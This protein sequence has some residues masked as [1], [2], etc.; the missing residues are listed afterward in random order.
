M[1]TATDE[2]TEPCFWTTEY[3]LRHCR[4]YRVFSGDEPIGFVEEIL[5]GEDDDPTALLVR[6][7]EVFTHLV[8]IPVEAIE[9]FDPARERVLIAPPGAT[10]PGTTAY[11]LR[12]P[13]GI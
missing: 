9:G 1:P 2:T 4:G 10:R 3:W 7:G 8:E 11:Q 6:V 12:I 13:A 5:D